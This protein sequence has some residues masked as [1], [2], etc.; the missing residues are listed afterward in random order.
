MPFAD[1]ER[2]RQE[3]RKYAAKKRAAIK[4]ARPPAIPKPQP[5]TKCCR[6]CLVEKPV[7]DFHPVVKK[8]TLQSR[9]KPCRNIDAA[10]SFLRNYAA[11]WQ[12]PASA[13][14]RQNTEKLRSG[15]I[16]RR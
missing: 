3:G 8:G 11:I 2:R 10:E 4:A 13:A 5:T 16:A 1:P 6:R 7:L 15:A 12:G 14:K 9:C